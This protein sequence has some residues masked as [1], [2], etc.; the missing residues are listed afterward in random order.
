ME[1]GRKMYC[2]KNGEKQNKMNIKMN[3]ISERGG[4]GGKRKK[5]EVGGRNG[6]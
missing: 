2:S 1:I 6:I 3:E 5:E 4:E